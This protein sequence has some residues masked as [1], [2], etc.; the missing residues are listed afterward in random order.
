MAQI[1]KKEIRRRRQRKERL[2]KLKSQF[3]EAKDLKE[4]DRLME[5][6]LKRDPFFLPIKDK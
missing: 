6:I 1:R 3:K 2:R 4:R 5:L